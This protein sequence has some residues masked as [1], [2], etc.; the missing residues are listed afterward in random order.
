MCKTGNNPSSNSP[1]E[2]F[3]ANGTGV[4]RLE[5]A[6]DVGTGTG[7]E[8]NRC[9]PW[10]CQNSMEKPSEEYVASVYALGHRPHASAIAYQNRTRG[11]TGSG[12][13]L[14]TRGI[15]QV[16]LSEIEDVCEYVIYALV[17]ASFGPKTRFNLAYGRM[18]IIVV[19]VIAV[20]VPLL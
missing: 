18:I 15:W 7:T 20:I 10:L 13:L 5:G 6:G 12:V 4:R 3:V 2:A 8:S 1:S 14:E 9:H 11:I 19:F 16:S 17:S